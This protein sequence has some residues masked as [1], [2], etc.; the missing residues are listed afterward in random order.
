MRPMRFSQAVSAPNKRK[1][2][3]ITTIYRKQIDRRL[4]KL[5]VLDL[6]VIVVTCHSSPVIFHS[7]WRQRLT[8]SKQCDSQ[9]VTIPI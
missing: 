2:H 8:P 4:Q 1:F 3:Q 6:T 5:S 7:M 9:K